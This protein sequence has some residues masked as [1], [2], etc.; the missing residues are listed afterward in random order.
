MSERPSVSRV[1]ENRMHGSKGGWGDGS[2]LRTPRP[3]TTN[4]RGAISRGRPS[5]TFRTAF[6]PPVVRWSWN[7]GADNAGYRTPPGVNLPVLPSMR[8][9]RSD[10]LVGS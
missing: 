4:G 7:R 10:R 3:L 6:E 2:A 5:T 1:R 8:G 9:Q